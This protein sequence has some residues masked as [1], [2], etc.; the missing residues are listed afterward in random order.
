V[1]YIGV[2]DNG[3]VA[4]GPPL[5]DCMRAHGTFQI[6]TLVSAAHE[7]HYCESFVPTGVAD[8][9]RGVRLWVANRVWDMSRH[10][11]A[12][13]AS[14]QGALVDVGACMNS[15]HYVR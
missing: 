10:E 14:G 6:V 15:E 8:V 11:R 13:P 12:Y 1:K 2:R 7:R 3:A 4:S 5:H 9:L